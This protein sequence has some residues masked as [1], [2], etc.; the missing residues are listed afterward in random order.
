MP[1]A[2]LRTRSSTSAPSRSSSLPH[3][4]RCSNVRARSH[5]TI[6]SSA[7]VPDLP[8]WGERVTIDHLVH[9]TGGVKERSRSGPGVPT[10]GVPGMGER[11]SARAAP[12]GRRARLRAGVALR[13]FEP[14]L[15]PA[16]RGRGRRLGFLAPRLRARPHLR[17]AGHARDLLPGR[18]TPLPANALRGHFLAADGTVREEPARFHAVGAG[19]LW[20]TVSDLARW[21]ANFDDDQLHRRVAHASDSRNAE[22]SPT[23]RRSTT[24]GDCRCAPI[25]G[26]RSSVTAAT[27]R[28]GSR[29]WCGS[30]P[31]APP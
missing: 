24:R 31:S 29:R 17:A 7:Y 12:R 19:G 16:G 13:L 3:A 27:S 15:P 5:S 23:A 4:S 6:P 14:R 10:E 20:T 25:A 8:A 9:H 21:D 30:R 22:R 28:A 18:E 2:P 11:G 26:C 1:M